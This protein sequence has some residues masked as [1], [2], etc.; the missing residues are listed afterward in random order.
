MLTH[1]SSTKRNPRESP[2]LCLP[3][4]LGYRIYENMLCEETV[5][6]LQVHR[7]NLYE[8]EAEAPCKPDL[9]LLQVSRQT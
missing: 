5:R 6:T 4:E 3:A 7:R 1:E 2:L 8:N 9:A